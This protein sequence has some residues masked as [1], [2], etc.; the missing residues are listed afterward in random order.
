MGKLVR[1][2]SKRSVISNNSTNTSRRSVFSGISA[3][4][5]NQKDDTK[6]HTIYLKPIIE[7]M[8]RINGTKPIDSD[9]VIDIVDRSIKNGVKRQISKRTFEFKWKSYTIIMSKSLKTI[10]DV[11]LSDDKDIITVHPDVVSIISKKCPILDY[12]TIQKVA[13]RA[14]LT[15]AFT[16]KKN[17]YRQ[18]FIYDYCG[19][20]IVFASNHTTIVEMQCNDNSANNIKQIREHIKL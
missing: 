18:Q 15:A 8:K 9:Y 19:C 12:F 2:S 17:D 14:K 1:N 4:H 5:N 11:T 10:L 20:R 6:Y 7:R 16:T 3:E 13:N